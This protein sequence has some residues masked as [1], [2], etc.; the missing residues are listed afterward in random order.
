MDC[1]SYTPHG[2]SLLQPTLIN[3]AYSPVNSRWFLVC[4][5][6]STQ[7]QYFH[8]RKM[9]LQH[10]QCQFTT[11]PH[12]HANMHRF[13][14]QFTCKPWLAGCPLDVQSLVILSQSILTRQATF[15][16]ANGTLGCTSHTFIYHQPNWGF[17]EVFRVRMSSNLQH[18][19]HA[20]I[21]NEISSNEL[22]TP[23]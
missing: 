6:V 14:D 18:Q 19:K 4:T 9:F 5:K 2:Q 13:N 22:Q 7:T 1:H 11:L 21:Y 16:C 3:A 23:D 20:M 10:F 17:E 12:T 8:L 15:L